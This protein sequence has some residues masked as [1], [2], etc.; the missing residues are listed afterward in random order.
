M[1][2]EMNTKN[3]HFGNAIGVNS[4]EGRSIGIVGTPFKAEEAYKL[5]A[6][7]LGADVNRKE[8]KRPRPR[9]VTYKKCS[10]LLTTYQEP[11]LREIQMYALESEMEQCVGR[12]RMLRK[13][14]TVYVCSAFPCEQAEIHME[15]YLKGMEGKKSAECD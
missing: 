1:T 7:Y 8:D 12:A 11:L 10:F 5:I 4:L 13:E 14:C 6:C 15:D 2:L 3:L 9:R